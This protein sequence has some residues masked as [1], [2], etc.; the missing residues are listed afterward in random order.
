M[1]AM[2]TFYKLSSLEKSDVQSIL[3]NMNR[4]LFFFLITLLYM[5]AL[6]VMAADRD[7]AL[8]PPTAVQDTPEARETVQPT[9]HGSTLSHQFTP[10]NNKDVQ[11]R[12][13]KRKNGATVKEYSLHG[14]VYMVKISPVTDT[15]PYYLYDDNGDGK[16]DRRLPGG[17]K[18]ISPPE[19]IIQH[20]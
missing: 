2:M 9:T 16:F 6:P 4:L 18:Y 7:A 12:I 15:P 3:G 13:Y 17:Y 8:S 19:W 5:P 14:R 11:V 10:E 1:G 20:F